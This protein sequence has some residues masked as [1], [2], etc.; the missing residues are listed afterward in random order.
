MLLCIGKLEAELEWSPKECF[1]DRSE[2]IRDIVVL[3]DLEPYPRND[4]N[5]VLIKPA[6]V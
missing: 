3:Y 4:L 6:V 5:N 2:E 1:W